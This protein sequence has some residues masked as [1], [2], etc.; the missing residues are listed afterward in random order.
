MRKWGAAAQLAQVGSSL[1]EVG[2]EVVDAV[3]PEV[4]SRGEARLEHEG[5]SVVVTGGP[6]LVLGAPEVEANVGTVDVDRHHLVGIERAWAAG[7]D[8]VLAR[9]GDDVERSNA[10]AA[11][12]SPVSDRS[13]G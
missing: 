2:L 1:F 7:S 3:Q 13:S 8:A 10:A 5:L 4:S 9:R 12:G 11:W 6:P